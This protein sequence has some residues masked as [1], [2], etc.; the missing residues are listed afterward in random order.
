MRDRCFLCQKPERAFLCRKNGFDLYRCA[1]CGLVTVEPPPSQEQLD[2]YYEDGYRQ[3]QYSFQTPLAGPSARE[4]NQLRTLERYASRGSLLDIGAAYG[5][6]MKCA[7]DRGWRVT[8][9]EPQTEARI[10]AQSRFRLA[11]LDTLD[12]APAES[13]DVI[14][15]WHV[16]EHIPTPFEFLGSIRNRLGA[17]GLLALTTPNIRSLSA[18]VTGESWGWLSPPDHVAMYSRSTIRLLLEQAGF[19]VIHMDTRRGAG[20]NMLLMLMQGIAFRLGLFGRLKNSVRRSVSDY[21]RARQARKRASIFLVVDRVTKAITFLI[22]PLL[23]MLWKIGLGDEV[24]VIAR[25]KESN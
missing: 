24:F 2:R 9:I 21:H 1:T 6:F 19:K 18:R 14:T 5:H 22:T 25:K 4:R 20:K 16:I 17:N 11:V 12:K 7:Q 10:L 8:G 3:F 23:L 15:M 13:F